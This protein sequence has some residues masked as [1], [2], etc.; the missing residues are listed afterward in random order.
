MNI[1][2]LIQG[3]AFSLG[4]PGYSSKIS[5]STTTS[6]DLVAYDSR[7][8]TLNLIAKLKR[9]GIVFRCVFWE[10]DRRHWE[11]IVTGDHVVFIPDV[12]NNTYGP[13]FD[14]ILGPQRAGHNKYLQFYAC[15]EGLRILQSLSCDYV[16]KVRTDTELDWDGL[17]KFFHQIK[18][19]IFSLR[20]LF[21]APFLYRNEIDAVEDLYFL[22]RTD[23]G[24]RVFERLVNG[25]ELKESIHHQ[26]FWTIVTS[27]SD[28]PV[29]FP[30][31]WTSQQSTLVRHLSFRLSGRYIGILPVYL[32]IG[33]RQRGSLR[34]DS[35]VAEDIH[36]TFQLDVPRFG[37]RSIHNALSPNRLLV[38][39]TQDFSAFLATCIR[40]KG[41]YSSVWLKSIRIAQRTLLWAIK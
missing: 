18:S 35:L 33:F 21:Y 11:Q 2:I 6:D 4:R 1:G 34:P 16:L 7:Q 41:K 22:I 14:S 26:L 8:G 24:I 39:L 36:K 15:Y 31:V 28:S 32:W 30:P 20:K 19:G 17:V 29:W 5:F 3:P 25:Y 38:F 37:G 10:S 27:N 12:K 40:Y 13:R 9:E 23:F